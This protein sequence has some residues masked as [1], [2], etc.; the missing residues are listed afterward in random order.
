MVDEHGLENILRNCSE[1]SK[2]FFRNYSGDLEEIER[3]YSLL[4][5]IGVSDKT[6]ERYAHLLTKDYESIKGNYHILSGWNLSNEV[7]ATHAY[8]LGY[9]SETLKKKNQVLSC[10]GIEREKLASCA[11]LLGRDPKTIE[12]HYHVLLGLGVDDKKIIQNAHLLG[13]SPKT[14]EKNYQHHVGLLRQNIENRDSGKDLLTN[15]AQL[16]GISPETI[17]SNVQYMYSLGIDYND[18]FLLGSVPQKKREKMAWLLREVFDYRESENKKETIHKMYDFVR[19]N[20]R[21]LRKSINALEK[22]KYE[23]RKKAGYGDRVKKAA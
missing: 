21:Y 14:I 5:E 11:Q 4:K 13:R 7:I 2:K 10:S 17:N 15:Q 23:I 22:E 3:R 9:N 6:I 12:E 8:L 1:F 19:D 16:L 20:L 18:A